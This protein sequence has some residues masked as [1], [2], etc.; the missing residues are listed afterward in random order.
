M[1][2][3]GIPRPTQKSIYADLWLTHVF[4][5]SLG[6]SFVYLK[7]QSRGFLSV[8]QPSAVGLFLVAFPVVLKGATVYFKISFFTT[9]AVKHHT[10]DSFRRPISLLRNS[11][12]CLPR[13]LISLPVF[14]AE[15]AVFWLSRQ[16]THPSPSYPFSESAP[17][18]MTH[19]ICH[20]C[21]NVSKYCQS[22]FFL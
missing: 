17:S 2:S 6:M 10:G 19:L 9:K 4:G 7:F 14:S 5:V 8:I 20:S 13:T 15:W 3:Q 22:Y 12:S 11:S 21:Y 1:R 18:L 16:T